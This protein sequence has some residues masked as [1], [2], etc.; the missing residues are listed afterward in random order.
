MVLELIADEKV[1]E[2][3]KKLK[4]QLSSDHDTTI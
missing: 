3:T 4:P 2:I 1:I